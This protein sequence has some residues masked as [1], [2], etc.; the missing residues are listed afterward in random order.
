MKKLLYILSAVIALPKIAAANPACAVCT[1]AVGASLGIARKLGVEDNIV[2]LWAGAM[3]ALVGYWAILWCNKKKWN[4]WGRDALMMLL[5]V[6]SIGFMYV[7]QLMYMPRPILYV[8]Y[9]DPF[10]F[11]TIAGA[12]LFIYTEKLYF[13]MKDRN[14]GHAHFPFEKVVLPLVVLFGA[15]VYLKYYPI[16]PM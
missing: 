13:W 2:A 14:G 5:S 9:M 6:G 3:L 10:L 4:F 7:E 12:L 15:S 11:C 16:L 1:I 8:F